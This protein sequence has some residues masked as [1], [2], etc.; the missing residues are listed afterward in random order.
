MQRLVA[1]P[2]SWY[3]RLFHGKEIVVEPSKATQKRAKNPIPVIGMEKVPESKN[4][5]LCT[6]IAVR[7]YYKAEARSYEPGYEI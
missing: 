7:A 6:R 2:S 4:D 3:R 5:D 1:A